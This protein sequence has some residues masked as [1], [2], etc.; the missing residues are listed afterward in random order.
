MTL[1]LPSYPETVDKNKFFKKGSTHCSR[2]NNQ[3]VVETKPKVKLF[4]GEKWLVFT[5]MLQEDAVTDEISWRFPL[6][7]TSAGTEI[8]TWTGRIDNITGPL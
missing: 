3:L 1:T 8:P 6:Y 7:P 2:L 5:G 4:E